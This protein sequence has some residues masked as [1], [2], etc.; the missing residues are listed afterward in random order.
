M[1]LRR[2][3][4][5]AHRFATISGG[6]MGV[7]ERNEGRQE[8]AIEAQGPPQVSERRGGASVRELRSAGFVKERR[9]FVTPAGRVR[10]ARE[11]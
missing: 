10:V 6:I 3:L 7:A 2:T 4:P 11:A 9:L 5:G 1:R 8:I